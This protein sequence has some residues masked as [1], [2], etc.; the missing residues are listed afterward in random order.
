MGG[1]VGNVYGISGSSA[2]LTIENCVSN[3]KMTGGA[4]MVGGLI[5]SASGYSDITVKNTA[6]LGDVSASGYSG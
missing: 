3:V 2:S 1:L 5:G 6:V 4:N